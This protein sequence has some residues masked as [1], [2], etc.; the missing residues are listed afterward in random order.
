MESYFKDLDNE[1]ATKDQE[2]SLA[3]KVNSLWISF[4]IFFGEFVN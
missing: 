2:I 3:G 1:T 4:V